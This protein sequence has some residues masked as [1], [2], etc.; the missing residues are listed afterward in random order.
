MTPYV[1]KIFILN[2]DVDILDHAQR[3]QPRL[4]QHQVSIS[5]KFYE[6]LLR[7]HILKAQKDTVDVTE[8]LSFLDLRV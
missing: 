5:S 1:T 3:Q 6:Q 8:Y 2:I 4:R 7:S